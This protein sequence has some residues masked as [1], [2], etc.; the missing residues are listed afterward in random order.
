MPDAVVLGIGHATR[1]DIII[2]PSGEIDAFLRTHAPDVHVRLAI[3]SEE[4][5]AYRRFAAERGQQRWTPGGT[6]SNT[7]CAAASARVVGAAA[8]S[9][10]ATAE[11]SGR[12]N[13]ALRP[14]P[15]RWHGHAEFDDAIL[16]DAGLAHLRAWGVA[17]EPVW[18]KGFTREAYCLIEETTGDVRQIAIYEHNAQLQGD[19]D[20]QPCDLLVM[21]LCDAL[22]ADDALLDFIHR[23]DQLALLIAD[24]RSPARLEQFANLRF[25]IGQRRDFVELALQDESS[26]RFA[27]V[28]A[29][30]ECIGTDGSRP[31][32]W[33]ERGARDAIHLPLES[34][35]SAVHVLGAGDAYAGAFLACRI[36][37]ASVDDAH[38]MAQAQARAAMQSPSSHV[39]RSDDLNEIFPAHIERRSSSTTEASFATR[40]HLSPGLVITSCGQTG[41]DQLALQTARTFGVTAFAIMPEGKRTECSEL[42]EGGP[43]R[44]DGATILELATPSYRFCT[45][46]NVFASDGTLLL[47]YAQSEGS[48]ET[49]KAARWLGRPVLELRGVPADD[50]AARVVEWLDRHAVRVL[51]CAGTRMTRLGD[52]ALAEARVMLQR[53]LLAAAAAIARRDCAMHAV[54]LAASAE[55]T[56]VIVAAPNS[57]VMRSLLRAFFD[58]GGIAAGPFKSGELT[59]NITSHALQV[60]FARSRD[61]PAMLRR[62]WAGYAIFGEDVR[63]ED[64]DQIEALFPLGVDPCRLVEI[65]DGE[66]RSTCASAWPSVA[67][68][69]MDPAIDVVPVTGCVEAWLRT[70]AIDC[71]IDTYQTGRAVE[72][73]GLRVARQ[74]KTVHAWMHRRAA[75]APVHPLIAAFARW[76]HAA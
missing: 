51:N 25:L 62:G 45:W 54:D 4:R 63:L 49:R 71:A 42:G 6:V 40:L 1:D 66:S 47:D 8:R 61:L 12:H 59:W 15:I 21:T 39:P 67:R 41:I 28:V 43:D 52:T 32:V 55:R 76:L 18:R 72:E 16:S 20:L 38:A 29:N 53:A 50:V 24:W 56:P 64:G 48:E 27:S 65:G 7:L 2:A 22:A 70:G 9:G 68:D 10:T 26:L 34:A 46:A 3:S 37:G 74:L 57:A 44:L 17:L 36:D 69:V 58:D 13:A 5:E 19:R 31:V 35:P 14:G 30:V 73:N 23:C 11:G 75:S 60:V 33:K